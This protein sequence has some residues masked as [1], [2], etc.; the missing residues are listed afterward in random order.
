MTK[1]R[2]LK[3]EIET[4]KFLAY[5]LTQE[6]QKG[7]KFEILTKVQRMEEELKYLQLTKQKNEINH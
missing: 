7:V 6:H 2:K 1:I 4:W 5:G 3:T